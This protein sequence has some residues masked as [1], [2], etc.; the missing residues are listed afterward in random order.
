MHIEMLPHHI[1]HAEWI[2]GDVDLLCNRRSTIGFF[3]VA[4]RGRRVGHRAARG[5][6]GGWR[7][8]IIH[9]YAS[10]TVPLVP[11]TVIICPVWMRRVATPVA[12]TAGM[13]YSRATIEP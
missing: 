2:G 7:L 3:P 9:T 6:G 1:I 13:P 11:S 12:I 8:L 4:V 10:V 5:D